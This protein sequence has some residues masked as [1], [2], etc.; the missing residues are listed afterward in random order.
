MP[1]SDIATPSE[2]EV[3]F[4]FGVG[5]QVE[6]QPFELATFLSFENLRRRWRRNGGNGW[7]WSFCGCCRRQRRD[8]FLDLSEF[9]LELFLGEPWD[10]SVIAVWP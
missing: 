3:E 7:R 8:L 9:A 1:D 5:D 6:V 2:Q 10:N 4:V